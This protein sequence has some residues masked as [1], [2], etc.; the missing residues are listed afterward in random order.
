MAGLGLR[1]PGALP[2]DLRGAGLG[3]SSARGLLYHSRTAEALSGSGGRGW[4]EWEASNCR[5][6]RRDRRCCS[7]S[8]TKGRHASGNYRVTAN[9]G[10]QRRSDITKVH[11]SQVFALSPNAQNLSASKSRSVQ[12]GT[13]RNSTNK[14]S[15]TRSTQLTLASNVNAQRRW[16]PRPLLPRGS[17]SS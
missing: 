4:P 12:C 1:L 9:Q 17:P 5:A 16:L 10:S 15:K 2:A 13:V 8:F 11:K 14:R 6:R 3:S 7:A